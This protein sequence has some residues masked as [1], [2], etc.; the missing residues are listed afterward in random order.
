MSHHTTPTTTHP[1][2]NDGAKG[3][4]VGTPIAVIGEEGDDLSG[5][6]ALAA[7]KDSAPAPAA[8]EKPKKADDPKPA[9]TTTTDALKTPTDETK[10]GSGNAGTEGQKAPPKANDSDKPKFFASPIARKIAL[11]RG[12]P[13]GQVK[14]TGPEGRITKEDV[15]KFSPGASAPASSA[16]AAAPAAEYEDAPTSNMRR[17]IGK[18]LSESKSQIP[19][20]YLTVEV[21][22]G[23]SR[24][25]LCDSSHSPQT[26]C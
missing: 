12:I 8:E 26:A 5:A 25:L 6:D 15:E 16:S 7:E 24:V 14:G 17:V 22:M 3:I 2:Q 20:Y 9:S 4:A 18:R 23:A 10:Y 13:L 11:E 21:N 1:Q 19:H